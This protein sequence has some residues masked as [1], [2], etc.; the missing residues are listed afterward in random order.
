MVKAESADRN[1]VVDILAQSFDSNKSFNAIVKQDEK[2]V[3]RIRKI[4]EYYF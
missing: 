3:L 2:R 1:I 4:F